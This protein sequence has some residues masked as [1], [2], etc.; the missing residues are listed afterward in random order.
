MIMTNSLKKLTCRLVVN[1][2]EIAFVY[3]VIRTNRFL[4]PSFKVDLLL[5]IILLSTTSISPPLCDLE[6]LNLASIL[7][8]K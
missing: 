5:Q 6:N 4:S 2:F 3:A 8:I 1:D 7:D